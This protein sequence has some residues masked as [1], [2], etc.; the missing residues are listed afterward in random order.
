MAVFKEFRV[1]MQFRV[2][3]KV[4]IRTQESGFHGSWMRATVIDSSKQSYHVQYDN[5]L[6]LE[7][8]AEKLVEVTLTP[9]NTVSSSRLR[10]L[11]PAISF[12]VFDF[13]YGLCVDVYDKGSWREGV[14]FDHEDG[15]SE[16]VVLLLES[17]KDIKTKIESFRISQEWDV[18]TGVWNPKGTWPLIGLFEGCEKDQSV[19]DGTRMIVDSIPRENPLID[20]EGGGMVVNAV[21]SDCVVFGKL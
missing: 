7:D 2:N 13:S 15:S 9:T 12:G 11:P 6:H 16:R 14:I 3:Q 19:P 1:T 8:G 17:G 20:H 21:D 18:H 10:P 5:L 4:E